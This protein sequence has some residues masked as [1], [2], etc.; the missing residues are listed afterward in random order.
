MIT[1]PNKSSKEWKE[2][3]N[4]I[5]EDKALLSFIRNGNEIPESEAKA[6]ELITNRGILESLRNMPKL[7]EDNIFGTLKANDLITGEQIKNEGKTW[8]KLSDTEDIGKKLGEYT[9]QYG[10]VLEYNNGYVTVAQESVNAWNKVAEVQSAEKLTSTRLAEEFLDKMGVSVQERDDILQRHGSNGIA[11]IAERMVLI[12]SG[13]RDLALPEEALHFFLEM[14]PQ[15]HPALVEALDKIRDRPIY[16][17][18]L[19]QYKNKPNYRIDGQVN[20]SKI[21]K[22]AL[23][24][25]IAANIKSKDSQTWMGRII[26]G[27]LNF[28]KSITLQKTATEKL[29]DLFYSDNIGNLN[30]NLNSSE[31]YNQLSDEYKS[32]YEAQLKEATEEQKQTIQQVLKHTASIN[33]NKEEHILTQHNVVDPD[34]VRLKS[35]T[36]VLGS[37]FYNEL[38]HI[39]AAETIVNDFGHHINDDKSNEYRESLPSNLSDEEVEK[40]VTKFQSKQILN[41]LTKAMLSEKLDEEYITDLTSPDIAAQMIK[42]IQSAQKTLFGTSV[43]NIVESLILGKDIDFDNLDP[44]I[45]HFMDKKTLRELIYGKGLKD[46]GIK[47]LLQDIQKD[48]TVL[49]TEVEVGNDSLG[50]VIDIIGVKPDGTVEIYDFKTKFLKEHTRNKEDIKEEFEQVTRTQSTFGVKNDPD[51]LQ[52]VVDKKRSLNQKFTQQLSLYKN[53]LMEA[54]VRVGS[55]NIIGVP[56]RLD[57]NGKVREIKSFVADPIGYNDKIGKHLFN[58][59]DPSLDASKKTAKK[60]SI[61][62]ERT[63]TLDKLSKEGL[64][65]TFTKALVRLEELRRFFNTSKDSRKTY[66][67]LT[68]LDTKVN[69]V[70]EQRSIVKTILDNF[71]NFNDAATLLNAQKSLLEVIDSSVGIIQT[72]TKEFDRLKSLQSTDE[73]SAQQRINELQKVNDFIAG[74]ETI[75]KEMLGAIDSNDLDNPLVKRL[76]DLLGVT[77][78]IKDQYINSILPDVVNLIKDEFSEEGIENMRRTYAENLIAAKQRGDTKLAENIQK[79]I[80]GLPSKET[81]AETIKGDRGDVGWFFGKF[82]ATIS[83]PDMILAGVAKRLK[84]VLDRVRLMNKDLRDNLGKEFDKRAAAYGRG[85]DI[86]KMNESLVYKVKEF[87]S[88]TG[89]EDMTVLYFKSEY[90]EKLYNDYKKLQYNLKQAQEEKDDAKV[91]A[92]RLA[93]KNFEQKYF[94]SDF[95]SEYFK[96]TGVLDK[97]VTYGGKSTTVREIVADIFDKL[98]SI[99]RRSNYTDE[100]ITNGNMNDEDLQERFELQQQYASLKEMKDSFGNPKTGED[101]KIAETLKEYEKNSRLIYDYVEMTALFNRKEQEIKLKYGENSLEHQEWIAKNTKLTTTPEYFTRRQ[102]IFDRIKQINANDDTS[103]QLAELYRELSVLSKPYRDLDGNIQAQNMK[104]EITEKIKNIQNEIVRLR[105]NMDGFI[106]NG[107]TAEEKEEIKKLNY[108]K[109]NDKSYDGDRLKELYRV[110]KERLEERMENDPEY[111]DKFD[112][113]TSLLQE[114]SDMSKTEITDHY[115]NELEKQ[116]RLFAEANNVSYEEFMKDKDLYQDFK[117]S[118]WFI[119]NHNIIKTVL[120]E[121]D[122]DDEAKG[123]STEEPIWC[124][125]RNMPVEKYITRKPAD[126]FYKRVLKDSYTNESGKEIKLKNTDNKDVQ[127]RYKPKSNEDYK[128]EYGKDHPYLN[129]EFTTLRD[130]YN[131][132]TA[133][134][135]EKVDYENLLYIHKAQLDAQ[136]D[137]ELS[138]RLG[139][140]VSFQEKHGMERTIESGGN[141]I[142]QKGNSILQGIKRSITST[143]QDIDQEGVASSKTQYSRLATMDNNEYK[144]VPVR[145]STKGDAEN[146]SYDVWGATLNYVA[147]INRK[148]ELQKEFALM[149]GLEKILGDESNQP[150]SETNN[151]IANSIFKKYFPEA[152]DKKI[153]SGSNVRLEVLKSF[154]NSILFNEESFKGYEVLGANSQKVVNQVMKLISRTT[155]GVAPFNW[156][157][158]LISGHV[159]NVIEAVGGNN[160]TL[161]GVMEAR[162]IIY[163][164]S[165]YG[166]PIKDMISD[167]TKSKVGNLS[168]WGQLMEIFDPIQGEFENEYG[169]KTQMNTIKNILHLGMYGGR[170]WG[171]WEIQMGTFIAYLGNNKVYNGRVMDKETFITKKVGDVTGLSLKEISSKKLEAIKE[172]DSLQTSLLDMFEKDKNGKVVI[173]DEF[174]DVFQLGSKDFSEVVA[175]LHAMQK[176]LN[177]SYN[178]FD[179]T[180][181]EKTSIGRMMMFFR[182][183]VIPLGVNRWGMRRENFE[184][185][186]AEEGFYLTFCRSMGKDLIKFRLNNVINWQNYSDAEKRAIKR[187]LTDVGIVLSCLAAYTLIGGYNENDK[188]KMKKLRRSSWANQAMVAELMKVK[189]ETEQFIPLP[190]MGL[191]EIKRMYSNPSLILSETTQMLFMTKLLIEQGVNTIPGVHYFD[192][193]LYYQKQVDQGGLGDEG[194]SKL[195]HELVRSFVGYSGKTFHPSDMV[196]SL[197]YGQRIK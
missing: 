190:D 24:K 100:D 50:G 132:K 133:S 153:N 21:K 11:D 68:D 107:N 169:H 101:L 34:G 141:N 74:Y 56:Y 44:I 51:T 39:Q 1:C 182:K 131:N 103:E 6:R 42:S 92:A 31:I 138:Q 58:I 134:E 136:K 73:A 12:Q 60:V 28:I 38:D 179:K 75:F 19:N 121:G 102:E 111:E 77:S 114:L 112:E 168:Y 160:I 33:F 192:N 35:V 4:K 53:I 49:M 151:L 5:G 127:D 170:V 57:E 126:H 135:K 142:L 54:G 26:D 130:K 125:K 41:D 159:Q 175:K 144:F 3:S 82:V 178:K 137:I 143:E 8:Y 37:D 117:N 27:I 45:E 72:V 156:A 181:I 62:D 85:L 90:D 64:K 183:H 186:T 17:Q 104:P 69:K 63:K 22:E 109:Y 59:T 80:D 118:D 95:T 155:L 67:L 174:K 106:M 189:S 176:R 18:T 81:I 166:N 66:E 154:V 128:K 148:R 188:D 157:T 55:L 123:Y 165:K 161:K 14:L 120:E 65:E 122:E 149:N 140:A 96:L 116:K 105:Q 7:S 163:T 79:R 124:W 20:F 87:N 115:F 99:Q 30:K 196:K 61:E 78:S 191:N 23:A 177:G 113:M 86:K 88:S 158:N 180:Y 195:L 185:M 152:A 162:K 16:S 89:K 139:L 197:E 164:G 29:Q 32:F 184:S 145:F 93:V 9:E 150:K 13:M 25:E 71:E 84:R 40:L 172:F 173:K 47:G 147:A 94:E 167:F 110:G 48:G 36:Q 2:L 119:Q 146:A 108:L 46:T 15:D 171:E 97:N 194:D 76:V 91:K 70:D 193:D 129:K 83:N 98:N 187:T 10:P 43:H 52:D